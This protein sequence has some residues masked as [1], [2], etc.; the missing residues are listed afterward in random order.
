MLP[1]F[2][3]N[4]LFFTQ[5]LT[6]CLSLIALWILAFLIYRPLSYIVLFLF[7]FC[8]W[9]FR[10]P[11]R[12]CLE[13]QH[14]KTVLVAPADGKVVEITFGNFAY[15]T[16]Q[17]VSIVLSLFDV[18]MQC[19]PCAGIVA[20]MHYMPGAHMV[21]FLPKSSLLNERHDLVLRSD[22][23]PTLVVSRIAG[24]LARRICWW[25]ETGQRLEGG[26]TFGMIR[27]G[28]RVDVFLPEEVTLEIGSGQHVIA[29]KTV[30]GRWSARS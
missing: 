13:L 4:N 8:L 15:G 10:N 26:N 22:R 19:V 28:S 6:L 27:F 16:T 7:I 11:T 24:M 20:D 30:L 9:F 3:I 2:I 29:G 5:G 18:H 25:V 1:S 17:K 21:S 23:G 14:D 12:E